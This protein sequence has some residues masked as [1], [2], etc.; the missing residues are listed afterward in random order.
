[1]YK[2]FKF[3]DWKLFFH[4]ILRSV[5]PILLILY[6]S[7]LG[8]TIFFDLG[9]I[10]SFNFV[11]SSISEI[12]SASLNNEAFYSSFFYVIDNISID[13]KFIILFSLVIFRFLI[14]LSLIF[15]QNKIV[16]LSTNYYYNFLFELFLEVKNEDMSEEDYS[17]LNSL[18]L[19]D[20]RSFTQAYLLLFLDN[21]LQIT[22]LLILSVSIFTF[23]SMANVF[24][25]FLAFFIFFIFR[26]FRAL[27]LDSGRNMVVSDSNFAEV[28]VDSSKLRKSIQ[29]N[30]FLKKHIKIK[31]FYFFENSLQSIT[32]ISLNSNIPVKLVESMIFVFFAFIM[33]LISND[34]IDFSDFTLLALLTI[35]L[36]PVL[37]RVQMST[38]KIN[39]TQH[40]ADVLN[41][42]FVKYGET[43]FSEK[44]DISTSIKIK[45]MEFYLKGKGNF[46]I[47]DFEFLEGNSYFISG[48][49]GSGKTTFV[50]FLVGYKENYKGIIYLDDKPFFSSYRLNDVQFVDQKASLMKG[51]ILDNIV[52]G[53]EINSLRLKEILLLLELDKVFS[54]NFEDNFDC[55]SKFNFNN[56]LSGGEVQ[57]VLLARALYCLKKLIILDEATN[58]LDK[59]SEILITKRILSYVKSNNGIFIF[60]SHNLELGCL[61]DKE[62]NLNDYLT[63]N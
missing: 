38:S 53:N 35:R 4:L 14:Y 23:S 55:I 5:K 52:L 16:I 8:I 11:F 54:N 32:K 19:K 59:V 17:L 13:L 3:S 34:Y 60:I 7:L 58:A 31:A 33:Y 41:S 24:F 37:N 56:N 20:L 40:I 15:L 30:Y 18:L 50:D 12:E 26:F 61:F 44:V 1:M 47:F 6:V 36:I 28:I 10:L 21:I 39:S 25:L 22:L 49:S 45:S 43:R 29:L 46:S 9:L 48:K 63:S 42:F 62:I 51:S 27:N 2:I 57:R